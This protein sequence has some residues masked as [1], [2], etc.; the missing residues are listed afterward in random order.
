MTL[1]E[2]QLRSYHFIADTVTALHAMK[3]RRIPLTYL[4]WAL[5]HAPIAYADDADRALV[6][7]IVQL[8][9]EFFA[10]YP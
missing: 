7:K 10:T 4:A 9:D 3:E 6:Q 2:S 5:V 1:S 8:L